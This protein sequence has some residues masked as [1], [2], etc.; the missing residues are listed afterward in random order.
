MTRS[1]ILLAA[2]ACGRQEAQAGAPASA[3]PISVESAQV[4]ERAMPRDLPLAG[5]LVSSQQADVAANA[6][7]RVM[8]TFVERG[9]FV[10]RGAALAQLDVRSA[11]LSDAEAEANLAVAR[12]SVGLAQSQC[13]RNETLFKKGAISQEERDKA[14]TQCRTSVG[15]ARAAQARSDLTA[16]ALRDATVRAPFA[17]MVAERF[18]TVGE[19]V[20]PDTKVVTL[21]ELNPL[22]LLLTLPEADIGQISLGQDVVFVVAAFPGEQFHGIVR[23]IGPSVR[24]ASRD[25]VVEALV[26]NPAR[27]LLPGMFASAHLQLAEQARPVVPRSALLVDGASAKIFALV[28]GRAEERLVQPGPERG[29]FVAIE[30]GVKQGER[31]ILQPRTDLR[32][33]TPVN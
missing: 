7:G 16:Q 33:G 15:S 6:T 28:N 22:R 9:A 11:R 14:E 8:R 29:G 27:R 19:Y 18:V 32:D 17:G 25:L 23:F 30:G 1:S 12:S 5:S 26:D 4:E 21:V 2:L 31:V 20:K 3:A 10:R 24:A 13:Q